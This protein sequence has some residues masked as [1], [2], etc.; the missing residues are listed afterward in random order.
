[1]VL[2]S[3][4]PLLTLLANGLGRPLASIE[5]LHALKTP[6]ACGNVELSVLMCFDFVFSDRRYRGTDFTARTLPQHLE[7]WITSTVALVEVDR[8]TEIWI[9]DT[10]TLSVL[11]RWPC[12]RSMGGCPPA[13]ESEERNFL[14]VFWTRGTAALDDTGGKKRFS[15][16]TGR[17]LKDY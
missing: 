14:R 1:M 15:K 13:K 11:E 8:S 7:K 2:P 17:L 9:K 5:A 10:S 12:R 6:W 3:D 4:R 16:L